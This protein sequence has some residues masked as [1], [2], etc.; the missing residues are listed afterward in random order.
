M[1]QGCVLTTLGLEVARRPASRP[2][3]T[4]AIRTMVGALTRCLPGRGR[5]GASAA[6]STMVGA[7]VLARLADESALSAEFLTAARHRLMPGALRKTTTK[8]TG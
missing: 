1:E 7:V 3:I 5:R 6:L 2:E 4:V 8:L